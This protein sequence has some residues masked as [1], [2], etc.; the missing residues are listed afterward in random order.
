MHPFAFLRLRFSLPKTEEIAVNKTSSPSRERFKK[1]FGD[2]PEN[3]DRKEVEDRLK[4]FCAL[5]FYAPED[6]PNLNNDIFYHRLHN[7]V[8]DAVTLA[9]RFGFEVPSISFA[10]TGRH[11]LP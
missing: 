10:P 3:A 11:H 6:D 4:R 8:I 2:Y 5:A 1:M 9:D 7:S